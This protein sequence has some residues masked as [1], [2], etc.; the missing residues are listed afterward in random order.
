VFDIADVV[1][2]DPRANYVRGFAA[3]LD[4]PGARRDA[5][6]RGHDDARCD[7]DARTLATTDRDRDDRWVA[8]IDAATDDRCEQ[9][10]VECPCEQ[11]VNHERILADLLWFAAI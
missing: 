2:I 8:W 6:R 4:G 10:D 9:R 7:D 1:A 5:V 11:R 3:E